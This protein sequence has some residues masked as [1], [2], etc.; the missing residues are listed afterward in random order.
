[1]VDRR[2]W[3]LKALH[4]T[5]GELHEQLA[6]VDASV[7]RDEPLPGEGSLLDLAGEIRDRERIELHHLEQLVYLQPERLRLHDLE[8]LADRSP[9]ESE[10]MPTLLREYDA[11][12]QESCALVWGLS[13]HRWDQPA[14]HPFRGPV[15]VEGLLTGL[16]EQDLAALWRAKQLC[17]AILTGPRR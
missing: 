16:H 9:Y 2:Q 17:T 1:M 8:W 3:L 7:A 6:A 11:L 14:H 4:E 12:R 13:A 5:A 15:T 10:G